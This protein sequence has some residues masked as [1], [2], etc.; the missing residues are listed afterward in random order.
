VISTEWRAKRWPIV[1][2]AVLNTVSYLL[3]LFALR[4]GVSSYIIGFRQLSI[5][6]GVVF[7]WRF[8]SESLTPGRR[9]GATLIVLGCGLVAAAR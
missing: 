5:A 2:V 7:G 4:E 3:I 8:L 1:Q 6:I 9:L